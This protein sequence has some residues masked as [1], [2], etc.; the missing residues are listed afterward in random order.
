[1]SDFDNNDQVLFL[2]V[3]RHCCEL[4]DPRDL[5]LHQF[6]TRH[7]VPSPTS[8]LHT[9]L[10][11]SLAAMQLHCYKSEKLLYNRMDDLNRATYTLHTRMHVYVR[12]RMYVFLR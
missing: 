1:M 7:L 2:S 10:R 11:V 12:V 5:A 9:W 8:S 6:S 3:I 4:S